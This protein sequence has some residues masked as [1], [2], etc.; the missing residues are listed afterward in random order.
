MRLRLASCGLAL[1][2]AGSVFA[3]FE[4][5]L[6]VE[7]GSNSIRR[8]DMENR[9]VLGRFG[10]SRLLNPRAIA[11]DQANNEAFVLNSTSTGQ[12]R[13]TVFNYFTG[14]FRREFGVTPINSF[15]NAM[16][17]REGFGLLIPNTAGASLYT[18]TG[19]LTRSYSSTL[20][21]ISSATFSQNFGE[22]YLHTFTSNIQRFAAGS[23]VFQ[24][25]VTATG[26]A[27]FSS[28]PG[29]L[30]FGA[31]GQRLVMLNTNTLSTNVL[32]THTVVNSF[33]AT[34]WGHT[35]TLYA[36]GI[37]P[38]GQTAI[39]TFDSIGNRVSDAWLLS[40]GSGATSIAMVNA[41][42]PGTLTAIGLGAA[43]LLRRRKRKAK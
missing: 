30:F 20:S 15:T 37:G 7:V 10:G 22:V 23:G 5:G 21:N 3:S 8:V 36:A 28:G 11:V 27:G 42:E 18:P 6:L 24:S 43:A 32:D 38:A 31:N 39:V 2:L 17:Y 9:I 34:A 14:E 16:T 41:P 4:M 13:V 33:Q 26:S 35:N 40:D 25:N 19:T 12:A 1:G 29:F